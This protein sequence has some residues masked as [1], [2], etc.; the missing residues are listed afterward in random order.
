MW[1]SQ[2]T[3][4]LLKFRWEIKLNI[5]DWPDFLSSFDLIHREWSLWGDECLKVS[6]SWFTC[7]RKIIGNIFPTPLMFTIL[8]VNGKFFPLHKSPFWKLWRKFSFPFDLWL[9]VENCFGHTWPK[10]A[11]LMMW[12]GLVLLCMKKALFADN[13]MSCVV[14]NGIPTCLVNYLY[15]VLETSKRASLNPTNC[16]CSLG[17]FLKGT[18]FE[19]VW[20]VLPISAN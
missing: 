6:V 18:V 8:N 20:S 13:I 9:R 2:L 3:K 11:L 16:Q 19:V 17:M 4:I 5:I 7:G 12:L 15:N 1:G 14:H 10:T